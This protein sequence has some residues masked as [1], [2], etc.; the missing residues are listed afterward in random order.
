[1][2]HLFY[3]TIGSNHCSK[4]SRENKFAF[5]VMRLLPAKAPKRRYIEIFV[6]LGNTAGQD[7]SAHKNVNLFLREP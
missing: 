1:M 5:W 6:R 2:K 3:T 4:G 7:A